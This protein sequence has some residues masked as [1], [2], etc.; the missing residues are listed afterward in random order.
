MIRALPAVA[1]LVLLAACSRPQPPDTDRPVEPK[2][3][4]RHDDLRR[5]IDT[6]LDKAKGVQATVDAAAKSEAAAIN[7]AESSDDASH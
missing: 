6:P 4:A 1:V 3:A 7:A 2:A 5:A